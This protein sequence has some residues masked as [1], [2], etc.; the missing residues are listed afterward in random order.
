[1]AAFSPELDRTAGRQ[2]GLVT[3][4]NLEK[5]G[6]T[7]AQVRW[8]LSQG[9]I[10]RVRPR[11]Y[12]LNGTPITWEQTLL[13]AALS[14]GNGAFITH[15]T[16]AALWT[17]RHVERHHAALH[18]TSERRIRLKGVRWHEG[19]LT[20]DQTTAVRGIPV[21]TAERTIVDCSA[22]PGL[23]T[24]QQLGECVDDAIRRKLIV[25]KRLHRLVDELAAAHHRRLGAIKGVLAERPTSFRPDDSNFETQMNRMWSQL[26]LPPAE[27]QVRV[28]LDGRTYRIDR[29]IV[30]RKIAIEWDSDRFHSYPSDRD[31]DSNRRARLVAAGWQV[32]P[33]TGNTTPE[34]LARAVLRLYEERAPDVEKRTRR[35]M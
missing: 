13:A 28:V 10:V 33:V 15:P 31:H 5:L 20:G 1:M 26:G 11:V 2:H 12:R 27:R 4:D 19:V 8:I 34:L 7:N 14:A 16:A 6:L 22:I 17:L 35:A 25:L 9:S 32:I 18:L 30:D 24:P 21:T 3:A 23:W 29:A